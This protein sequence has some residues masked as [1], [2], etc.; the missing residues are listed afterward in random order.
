MIF[1]T[2]YKGSTVHY[3]VEKIRFARPDIALIFLRQHLEFF[4]NGAPRELDARP[5]AFAEN[6]DGEWKIVAMQNTR[7]SEAGGTAVDRT[8]E[9]HPYQAK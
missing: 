3:S 6:V 8:L 7:I 2:I 1:G 5:T 9:Q 4:E